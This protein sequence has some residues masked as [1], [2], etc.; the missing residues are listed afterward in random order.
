[1]VCRQM[2]PIDRFVVRD[3]VPEESQQ[4]QLLVQIRAGT[5]VAGKRTV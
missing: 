3:P 5:G 4:F 1:M 2:A